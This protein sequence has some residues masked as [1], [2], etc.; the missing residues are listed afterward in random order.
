MSLLTIRSWTLIN[1]SV[2][3]FNE[4][5]I[6]KFCFHGF[7]TFKYVALLGGMDAQKVPEKIK[8]LN[9]RNV[10]STTVRYKQVDC[11]KEHV[12][13]TAKMHDEK[14]NYLCLV[15]MTYI[16]TIIFCFMKICT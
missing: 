11:D 4:F 14:L 6:I 7:Y 8:M 15:I 9:L 3:P 2:H 16:G 10:A 5:H 1:I 12:L 13:D